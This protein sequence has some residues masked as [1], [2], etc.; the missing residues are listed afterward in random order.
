[1]R[2]VVVFKYKKTSSLEQQQQV[3]RAFLA[4]QDQIPGITS[5]EHG[6]NVSPEKLDQGFDHVFLV[7]FENTQARDAYL[8]HPAHLAFGGLLE[9]LAVIE[10]VFVVDFTPELVFKSATH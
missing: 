5:I 2:H 3:A 8:P 9:K 6:Q 10:A 1:M 7:T 4:L